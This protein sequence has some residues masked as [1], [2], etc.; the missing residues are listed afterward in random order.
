M[1]IDL[2]YDAKG[3]GKNPLTPNEIENLLLLI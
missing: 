2:H 3:K 1:R